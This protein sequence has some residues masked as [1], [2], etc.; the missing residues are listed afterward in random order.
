VLALVPTIFFEVGMKIFCVRQF[1]YRAKRAFSNLK[2]G[3]KA[4]W[5]N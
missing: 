5:V 1:F 3:D 2:N 4:L